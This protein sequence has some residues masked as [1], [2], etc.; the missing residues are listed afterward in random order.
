[1]PPLSFFGLLF[2]PFLKP[3]PPP[4]ATSSPHFLNLSIHIRKA[5][6]PPFRGPKHSPPLYEGLSGTFSTKQTAQV[7][8]Q[9]RV[10]KR[11]VL[12]FLDA[13]QR[14]R[15]LHFLALVMF[16]G[17][18]AAITTCLLLPSTQRSR[19]AVNSSQALGKLKVIS[20]VLH[21]S[22]WMHLSHRDADHLWEEG[23]P[24]GWNMF[25]TLHIRGIFGSCCLDFCPL[26]ASLETWT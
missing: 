25:G 12:T 8:I 19:D 24:I 13:F 20:S 22:V 26:F 23:L 4:P 5:L 11:Y 21:E 17:T 3:P 7:G 9:Q 1:M 15:R 10:G 16:R 18:M 14:L 2:I 6:P